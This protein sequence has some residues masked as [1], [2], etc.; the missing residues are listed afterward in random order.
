MR[1]YTHF[2]G[3]EGED[4]LD[5]YKLQYNLGR[6]PDALRTVLGPV[7]KMI[8][9]ER[10]ARMLTTLRTT[11]SAKEYWNTLANRTVYKTKF[12]KVCVFYCLRMVCCSCSDCFFL[13]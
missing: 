6:I 2:K 12:E 8:L 3:L 4:L 7:I 10:M 9:G 11:M 13:I 1:N 5:E